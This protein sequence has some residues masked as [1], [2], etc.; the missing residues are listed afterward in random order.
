MSWSACSYSITALQKC[1]TFGNA[2]SARKWDL[3]SSN[4]ALYW[5]QLALSID[6]RNVEALVGAATVYQYI[7][8]Q[9][10]WHNNLRIINGAFA[11]S[12]RL[13][14]RANELDPHDAAIYTTMGAVY[15]AVGK[16]EI[17]DEYFQQAITLN[18]EFAPA[19][20]FL[21]FNTL[22]VSPEDDVRFGIRKGIELA[23]QQKNTRQ[24]AAALY[25]SG[26]ANTLYGQYDDA[27][28]DLKKSLNLN[29]GYGSAHLALITA[30]TLSKHADAFRAARSFRDKHPD[31]NEDIL[32]YMWLDRSRVHAYSQ[33]LSP[34]LGAL[35]TRVLRA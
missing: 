23:E 21:N 25:F 12:I 28:Q 31:F 1:L 30:A 15:S 26:F 24:M 27:I 32:N 5:F 4:E 33:L 29:P 11:K 35:K 16:A 7:L 19:H 18:S 17:A 10:W 14:R 8:S 2:A 20:Y 34:M 3:S 13:L 6:H 22:F 9:P